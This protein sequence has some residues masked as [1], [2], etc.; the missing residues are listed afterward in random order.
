LWGP[1]NFIS[2]F[3]G[4]QA[5]PLVLLVEVMHTSDLIFMTLEGL[6]YKKNSMV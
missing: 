5:V 2:G 4:F 6:H 1:K 3:E